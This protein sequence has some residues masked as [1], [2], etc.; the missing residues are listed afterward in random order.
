MYERIKRWY[1]QGLWTDTMIDNAVKK[2]VLSEEQVEEI[3][4]GAP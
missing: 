1:Q 4:G 3:K 2:G